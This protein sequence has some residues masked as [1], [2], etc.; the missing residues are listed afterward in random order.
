MAG[1]HMTRQRLE[2]ILAA[3]GSSPERWPIAERDA[4]LALMESG[5]AGTHKSD[6]AGL[7]AV[8]ASAERPVAS[9]MLKANLLEAAAIVIS[10][11]DR[12]LRAVRR[13]ERNWLVSGLARMFESFVVLKPLSLG[14]AMVPVLALG[15]WIG[16]VVTSE[17]MGEDELFAAFGEDYGLWTES[18]LQSDTETTGEI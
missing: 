7:D 12:Q 14:A 1:Q 10:S 2:A 13:S 8:L 16:A 17:P 15:I 6:E 5:E 9:N 4:A 11:E 3:Y 18:D